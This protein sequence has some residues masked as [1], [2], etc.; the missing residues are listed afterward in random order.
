M[1]NMSPFCC[2]DAVISL[3]QQ[4][5]LVDSSQLLWF[6]C[7][8]VMLIQCL[9]KLYAYAFVSSHCIKFSFHPFSSVFECLLIAHYGSFS[10]KVK[11][12][13]YSHKVQLGMYSHHLM[14]FLI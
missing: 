6:F 4:P 11:L 10:D 12:G 2:A 14:L 9:E 5:I 3:W 13:M 1:Y 7:L 8:T